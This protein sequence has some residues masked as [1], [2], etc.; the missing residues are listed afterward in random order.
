MIS[1]SNADESSITQ[2]TRFKEGKLRKNK[3]KSY[4]FSQVSQRPLLDDSIR[5]LAGIRK[6]S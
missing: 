5:P 2:I 4:Y 1:R 6:L 3:A